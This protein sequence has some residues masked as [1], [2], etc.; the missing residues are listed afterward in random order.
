MYIDKRKFGCAKNTNSR[1]P[2]LSSGCSSSFAM[3]KHVAFL[4]IFDTITY[5]FDSVGQQCRKEHCASD[6]VLLTSWGQR[7][8]GII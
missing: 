3:I 8:L 4:Y 5:L 1:Y 2:E 7:H 6:L